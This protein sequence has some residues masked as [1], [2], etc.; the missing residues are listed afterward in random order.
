MTDLLKTT[1]RMRPDRILVGEVRGPEALDLL[2][3]WNTGHEG[4]AATVHA[5][6]PL[7]ALDR[8]A[9]LISMNSEYPKPIEPLIGSSIHY[10]VHIGRENHSRKIKSILKVNGYDTIN[11]TYL[12][13]N[14]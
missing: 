3:A 6:N 10:I 7:A 9:L 11:K 8:I 2:M 4:G 13:E 14:I 1:L 12:T 5:N